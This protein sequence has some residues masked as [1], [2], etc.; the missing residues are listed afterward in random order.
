MTIEEGGTRMQFRLAALA[1][2]PVFALL[3]PPLPAQA[4][5]DKPIRL[6]VPYPPGGGNDTLA[7]MFGAKLTEAWGQQIIVDN[8]GGAGTTIGTALAARAV[9]DGYTV[10]LSSIATHALAPNLYSKPGYDPIRDFAPITLLAIAPT[11]LCVNPSVPA[12]SVK[13]LIALAKARPDALKY[14]SGGN[15]T[16]PHM[17]GAI[18]AST[19]GVKLLHVPYKGG[20]P[21]IAGLIGGETNMMFDTAASILPH[22]R[23]GK[24]KALAIARAARLAEYPNLPTFGEAGVPGY[25]V[26]AWY[27][28]H[29][30]AGTPKPIIARWNSELRRILKLAD[31][32][33]RLRQLGSEAV[34]NSPEAFDQFVRAESAKY[35]RAIKES[36]T[37]VD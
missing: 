32:Q 18:F 33:E 27:S 24:L 14:A 11:V 10:L 23:G 9:P 5:P 36:G 7:R 3:P 16:P 1:L 21:A 31:I 2:A 25:E 17:A 6:I 30:I 29:A 34:G 26:N 37:R 35:A 4:Y 28:M 19:T 20:G 8:R 15:G 12:N 13:E 22:V